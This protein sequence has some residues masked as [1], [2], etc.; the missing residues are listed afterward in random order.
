MKKRELALEL[1]VVQVG[2]EN[3]QLPWR[4]QSFVNHS[5]R[6]ERAKVDSTGKLGLGPLAEE[7]QFGLELIM[8]E[9]ICVRTRLVLR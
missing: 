6:R 1:L 5:A 8:S 4:Q 7:K 9:L 3:R 2:I